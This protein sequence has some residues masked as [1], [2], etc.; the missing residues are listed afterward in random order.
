MPKRSRTQGFTLLELLIAMSIFSVLSAM[1][2][3]GLQAVI[4]SKG[5]TEKV[6]NRVS[7]LQTSMLFLQRD[8]EQAVERSVRDGFGDVAPA[9]RGGGFGSLVLELTRAGWRNP[10]GSPRSQLQRV[11]YRLSED[12]EF[13]RM[14]WM[15]LD[16]PSQ[17]EPLER[18]LL[19]GVK[20]VNVRFMN[21]AKQWQDK[22]PED[23]L[24]NNASSMP[25]AVEVVI[26]FEDMGDIRRVFRV[27]PGETP[28]RKLLGTLN[29][30]S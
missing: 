25:L 24:L 6:A 15:V 10:I 9:L 14:A 27:P 2:F 7:E 3:T 13:T 16:Q 17:L 23:L 19:T 4:T 1:A 30:S 20:G 5:H 22:W 29:A 8:V 11:A 26:E 28:V 12:G 18:V 21:P